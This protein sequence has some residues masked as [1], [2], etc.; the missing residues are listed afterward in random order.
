MRPPTSFRG[1]HERLSSRP[2]AK[3]AGQ[4]FYGVVERLYLCL[5]K[6][7]AFLDPCSLRIVPWFCGAVHVE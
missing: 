5:E 1:M 6:P 3:A 2:V 4:L 7:Q